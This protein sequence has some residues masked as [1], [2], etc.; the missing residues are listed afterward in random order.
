MKQICITYTLHQTARVACAASDRGL[1]HGK[2]H[3]T[4]PAAPRLRPGYVVLRGG[5]RVPLINQC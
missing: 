2:T 3:A 1:F 5:V 4:R